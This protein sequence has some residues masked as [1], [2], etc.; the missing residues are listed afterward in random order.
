MKPVMIHGSEDF[1]REM[2]DLIEASLPR[3]DKAFKVA[4]AIRRLDQRMENEEG[5]AGD[6]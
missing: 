1:Q 6:E 4:H 2:A 3:L 5:E